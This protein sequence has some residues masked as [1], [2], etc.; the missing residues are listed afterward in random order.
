[1]FNYKHLISRRAL[2]CVMIV[3]YPYNNTYV[4]TICHIIT[5]AGYN[6]LC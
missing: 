1:M 5:I 2:H 3:A 4:G 6:I